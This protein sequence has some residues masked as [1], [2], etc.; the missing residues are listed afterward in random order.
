MWLRRRAGQQP[1]GQEDL[2]ESTRWGGVL[3]LALQTQHYRCGRGRAGSLLQTSPPRYSAPATLPRA[4][5]RACVRACVRLRLHMTDGSG[6]KGGFHPNACTATDY[7]DPCSLQSLFG[8]PSFEYHTL[9]CGGKRLLVPTKVQLQTLLV[10]FV[11][12][13]RPHFSAKTVDQIFKLKMSMSHKVPGPL[14]AEVWIGGSSL[15]FI[16]VSVSPFGHCSH[17]KLPQQELWSGQKL[18]LSWTLVITFPFR[19]FNVICGSD[20]RTAPFSSYGILGDRLL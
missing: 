3:K 20:V 12:S 10:A 7:A 4:G 15:T 17:L 19:S 13:Q 9:D 18:W 1:Q 11:S 14:V 5:V 6:M 8:H 16:N 2:Q